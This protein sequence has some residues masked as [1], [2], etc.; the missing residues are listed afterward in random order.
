MPQL[1]RRD[2]LLSTVAA[3]CLP[4]GRFAGARTNSNGNDASTEV[5]AC[6]ATRRFLTPIADYWTHSQSGVFAHHLSNAVFWSPDRQAAAVLVFGGDLPTNLNTLEIYIVEAKAGSSA[7]LRRLTTLTTASLGHSSGGGANELSLSARNHNPLLWWPDGKSFGLLWSDEKG[8]NQVF[9]V[10][11]DGTVTQITRQSEPVE[12]FAVAADG[13]LVFAAYQAP[14]RAAQS[15]IATGGL[16]RAE[17]AMEFL[18]ESDGRTDDPNFGRYVQRPNEPPSKI[19][20]ADGWLDLY[21]PNTIVVSPDSR[22]AII[23]GTPLTISESWSAY[24]NSFFAAAIREAREDRNGFA[25]RQLKQAYLVDLETAYGTP[26]W[27]ALLEYGVTFKWSPNSQRILATPTFLPPEKA[28]SAGL[29]GFAAAIIEIPSG[30]FQELSLPAGQASGDARWRSNDRVEI[31]DGTVI[32]DYRLSGDDWVPEAPRTQAP[33]RTPP[34]IFIREALNTP[35]RLFGRAPGGSEYLLLDPN[36][37]LEQELWVPNATHLTWNSEFGAVEGVMYAPRGA[38]P[39]APIPFVI[40]VG[41]GTFAERFSLYG[42]FTAPGLGPSYSVFAAAPL[43]ASG[44]GV[45]SICDQAR[46]IEGSIE[47]GEY[48]A[49]IYSS[50]FNMLRARGFADPTRIGILGFSRNG[51]RVLYALTHSSS[52]YAAALVDDCFDG[53]YV[54]SILMGGIGYEMVNGPLDQDR[55]LVNWLQRAPGFNTD[56][57]RCPLR[58]QISSAG[59]ESAL[60]PWEIYGRLKRRKA[61]VELFTIPDL[62]HGSHGLQNP[63]Q[64]FAAKQGTVRWFD[65]WLNGAAPNDPAKR[66]RYA[67]RGTT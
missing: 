27:D 53:S 54:Q 9:R 30:K 58:M 51:F 8:V 43:A 33:A 38:H 59:A 15:V 26:L 21:Q 31:N 1:D 55:D 39:A 67:T 35:A 28:S 2:V 17:S 7:S 52:P 10:N 14:A 34:L 48:F 11:L 44:I 3:V 57:I 60:G 24:K 47:E 66:K 56:H 22:Y 18:A 45:L 16:I 23:D 65:F 49:K 37:G 36:P 5:A 6:I 20:T 40:Q 63:A 19:H 32:R 46:P 29:E 12:L 50:A 64:V 42:N 41:C 4:L 62:E 61:P 13:T 25:A